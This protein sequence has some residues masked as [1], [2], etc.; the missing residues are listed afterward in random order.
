MLRNVILAAAVAGLVVGA[1]VPLQ[2]SPAEAASGCF[3]AAKVKYSGD[4]KA[5]VAYRKECKAH[6]KT[7]KTAHAG[8]HW[9]KKAA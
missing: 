4:Y 7:Y 6:W 5:R 1:A 2:S 3:K 9:F 8:H